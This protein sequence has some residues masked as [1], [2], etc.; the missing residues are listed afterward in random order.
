[1]Y[2]TIVKR[3]AR[4]NFELVNRKGYDQIV[5][6]CV[7]DVRHRFGGTHALG[8]E[9][10]DAVGLRRWFD[11]LGRLVPTLRLEV[12][13]LWATG[14]PWNTTVIIRWVGTAR[15]PD[16]SPYDQHGVHVVGLRWGKVT[17]IDANEDSQAVATMLDAVAATGVAEASAAP[18]VT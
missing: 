18:I 1:M 9:R 2:F 8:G 16:G 3:L 17:S 11:R 14:P 4:R 13:D 12:T 15:F 6:S 5:A 10:H 7:P